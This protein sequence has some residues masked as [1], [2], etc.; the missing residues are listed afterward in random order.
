MKVITNLKANTI[1]E[2]GQG[3]A[4]R[5]TGIDTGDSIS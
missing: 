3:L 1:I 5:A 4:C 2:L